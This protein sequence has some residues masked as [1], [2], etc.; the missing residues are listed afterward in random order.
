MYSCVN[1]M[2]LF[3]LTVVLG[4]LILYLSSSLPSP[5]PPLPPISPGCGTPKLKDSTP[6]RWLGQK[7]ASGM[8]AWLL[9]SYERAL[10]EDRHCSSKRGWAGGRDKKE[11]LAL[12]ME[13]SVTHVALLLSEL[14]LFDPLFTPNKDVLVWEMH[15]VNTW[16][17]ST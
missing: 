8:L 6:K 13:C 4:V 1:W 9:D 12:C 16:L 11:L 10:F 2:F 14:E 17:L 5:P 3:F 15:I 7:G